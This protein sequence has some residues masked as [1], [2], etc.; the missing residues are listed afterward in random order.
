MQLIFNLTGLL[1]TLKD[2]TQAPEALAHCMLQT[3]CR[4]MG[5][6]LPPPPMM[7]RDQLNSASFDTICEMVES[8]LIGLQTPEY[9][10]LVHLGNGIFQLELL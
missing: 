1:P 10:N 7:T 8:Q 6:P 4:G 3:A 2:H 5:L 9:A